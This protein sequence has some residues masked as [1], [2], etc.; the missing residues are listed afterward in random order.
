MKKIY[1]LGFSGFVGK[2]L[3]SFLKLNL[4]YQVITV[5]RTG[6]DVYADLENNYSKLVEVME[7]GDFLIFL[8][9]ISSPDI[10]N[11]NRALADKVNIT[12]TIDLIEKLNLKGVNTIFSST[13]GVFGSSKGI[14]YDDSSLEPFGYYAETKANVEYQVKDMENVKVVRFSYVFGEGDKYT[15][16]LEAEGGKGSRIDVFN[17]FLRNIVVVDDVILGINNLIN[18]WNYTAVQCINFSGP[19]LISRSSLTKIIADSIVHGL[20]IQVVDAPDDF[21]L[22]RVKSIETKSREFE[23]ILGRPLTSIKMKIEN[24]KKND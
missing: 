5:G 16:M 20:K 14:S 9:S 18:R 17:G 6:A 15:S 11:N 3:T 22:S 12:S 2:H 8:S 10:C 19:E 13:D 4:E 24:W 7:V 23:K 1:I 21:W